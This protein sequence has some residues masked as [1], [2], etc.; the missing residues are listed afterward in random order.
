MGSTSG[1]MS[2]KR[3]KN[4]PFAGSTITDRYPSRSSAEKNM[5]TL[6]KDS[7]DSQCRFFFLP[8]DF[9]MLSPVQDKE[10]TE[11]CA[12]KVGEMSYAHPGAADSGN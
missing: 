10:E 1:Y 5:D 12:A 2:P 8:E 9:P 11:E 7:L 3:V 4:H 6:P